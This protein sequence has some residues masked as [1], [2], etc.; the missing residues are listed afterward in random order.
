MTK[1]IKKST[2]LRPSFLLTHLELK[3]PCLSFEYF[4]I[5]FLKHFLSSFFVEEE[6]SSVQGVSL[7][8]L[9]PSVDLVMLLDI[10]LE[11]WQFETSRCFFWDTLLYF[12]FLVYKYF[13]KSLI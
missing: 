3:H 12:V 9:K 11:L 13:R 4:F 2:V 1:S 6:D 8:M 5:A 10:G 7:K